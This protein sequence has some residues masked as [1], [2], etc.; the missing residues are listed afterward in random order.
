MF[1]KNFGTLLLGNKANSEVSIWATEGRHSTPLTGLNQEP[2]I[3][4]PRPNFHF[5]F[6]FK[7]EG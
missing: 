4:F 3:H 7:L 5:P 2:Q 1:V 6:H